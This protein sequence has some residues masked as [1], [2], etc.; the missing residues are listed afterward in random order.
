MRIRHRKRTVCVVSTALV[1]GV[2]GCPLPA[3]PNGQSPAGVDLQTI[4][5]G[6]AAPNYLTHAGDG[7]GRLFIV[8]QV[9]IV[10]L[11]RDGQ[12]M[13]EPF[14]DI[15]ERIVEL[16][17]LY[18]ER[19]LLG[20]AFHPGFADPESPGFGRLYTCQ[21]EPVGGQADFTV[22]LPEGES[23]DHQNVVTEW[24][25]APDDPDAANPVS[26]REILRCD[27]PQAN[28]DAGQLVF[29]PDGYLYI[30]I[31]DGGGANDVGPGHSP[32]GNAQDLANILGKILRIDPLPPE[33]TDDDVG[34]VSANDQ[35]RIPADNPFA[36]G[37]GLPEIFAYGLRN[38]YR[39][40]FDPQTGQLFAGDVGQAN[41]EEVDI[42]VSGGNYGWPLKEGTFAF[43]R[44]TGEI[45]ADTA[46]LPEGLIDP[47]LEYDH[48]VGKAVIGGFVYRGAG[49]PD[50]A[51]QYVFGDLSSSVALPRGRIFQADPA[52]GEILEM[53]FGA[54]ERGL[55]LFLKG[56][57]R[58][59]D[60]ELY[61]L[62]GPAAGPG[63]SGGVA[64][65]IV[66]IQD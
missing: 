62:G 10:W 28:H 46:G 54:D 20:L 59:E 64:L 42:I 17:S 58:D 33:L 18:D 40:S 6:M 13:D 44:E 23:F 55:G 60:G 19:G 51:G 24:Q 37:G 38:P 9:G 7:S 65:K 21:S 16:N 50:L 14:L 57:G 34:P 12:R 66:A 36:D 31:G 61:I 26:G 4:A 27:H 22:P 41:I 39:F 35:Y 8:D 52:G 43:N 30:G 48:D 49:A 53:F 5:E 56:F 11:V 25:V 63:G 45:S 1:L 2:L 47:I 29:G 3:P 32:Q 15:R